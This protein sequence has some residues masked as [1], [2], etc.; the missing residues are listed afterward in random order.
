MKSHVPFLLIALLMATSARAQP[1]QCNPHFV[2]PCPTNFDFGSKVCNMKAFNPTTFNPSIPGTYKSPECDTST[3][4]KTVDP[5]YLKNLRDAYALAPQ[6]VKSKLCNLQNVFV[7]TNNSYNS[8]A[9]EPLGIWEGPFRDR[10]QVY[11]AIPDFTLGSASSLADEENGVLTRLL[12]DPKAMGRTLPYF[13]RAAVSTNPANKPAAAILAVLAHELGHILLA[14]GNFDAAGAANHRPTPCPLP[15]NRCFNTNFLDGPSGTTLWN[16]AHF[17]GHLRRW[18]IFND[19]N[20]NIYLNPNVNFSSIKSQITDQAK[21]ADSTDR[22]RKIYQAGLV[23]VFAAVSPEEDF[24]ET[25][26]YKVLAAARDS[27]GAQLDLNVY[28][29]SGSPTTM[30]V[31]GPVASPSG[32]LAGK[33]S[34]V[35]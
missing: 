17:H 30:D 1:H 35:P 26:K 12:T 10:E 31:L 8:P 15:A 20:G 9:R 18:I 16:R 34:C 13:Q 19:T 2:D 23:S 25:Y 7:T 21:D 6:S 4:G 14:D 5:L 27:G 11:I 24:V 29:P 33:I 3:T 28:F 22:I 32:D